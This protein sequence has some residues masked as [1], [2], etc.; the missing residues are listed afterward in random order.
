MIKVLFSLLTMIIVR[1]VNLNLAS[2]NGGDE[3]KLLTFLLS[4]PPSR[5]KEASKEKHKLFSLFFSFLFFTRQ[6]FF[7]LEMSKNLEEMMILHVYIHV[8]FQCTTT[9]PGGWW[10]WRWWGGGGT[11]EWLREGGGDHLRPPPEEPLTHRAD[12]ICFS[13]PSE[14]AALHASPA[15]TGARSSSRRRGV[16]EDTWNS[17]EGGKRPGWGTGG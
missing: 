1:P 7:L 17:R 16:W 6:Q 8:T 5:E 2:S 10:W 9:V 15:E 11:E 12:L 14:Q 3:Q 13:E 4:L